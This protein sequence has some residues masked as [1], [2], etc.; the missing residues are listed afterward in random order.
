M[1]IKKLEWEDRDGW[2]EAGEMA[3]VDHEEGESGEIWFIAYV[4][5]VEGDYQGKDYKTKEEAMQAAQEL[6]EEW[7][8]S[9]IEEE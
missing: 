6:F 2:W 3:C 1:K 5:G 4:T 9:W 8:R 7:I